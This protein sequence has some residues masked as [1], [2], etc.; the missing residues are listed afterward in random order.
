MTCEN[1]LK[2]EDTLKNF[3]QIKLIYALKKFYSNMTCEKKNI[4]DTLQDK[5]KKIF[6]NQNILEIISY[7]KYNINNPIDDREIYV[8][9]FNIIDERNQLCPYSIDNY[10]TLKDRVLTWDKFKK[11]INDIYY[12]LLI[13]YENSNHLKAVLHHYMPIYNPNKLKYYRKIKFQ[14]LWWGL[15]QYMV[16]ELM[17]LDDSDIYFSQIFY[18]PFRNYSYNIYKDLYEDLK[19]PIKNKKLGIKLIEKFKNKINL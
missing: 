6:N 2:N 13:N 8:K 3:K 12:N 7:H 11:N 4:Q 15:A 10:K 9:N 1:I 16:L 17:D 14:D 19:F 18:N 5:F